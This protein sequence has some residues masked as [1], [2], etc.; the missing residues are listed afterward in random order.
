MISQDTGNS[1]IRRVSWREFNEETI[2]RAEGRV[3]DSTWNDEGPGISDIKKPSPLL[4]LKKQ[5]EGTVLIELTRVK[6][7]CSR[8]NSDPSKMSVP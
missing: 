2:C 7:I 1:H 3:K 6:S 4:D 8:K 5:I